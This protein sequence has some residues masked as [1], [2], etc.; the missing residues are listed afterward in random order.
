LS[1]KNGVDE[2]EEQLMMRYVNGMNFTIQDEISMQ[3]MR[4]MEEDCWLVLK[5]KEKLT[6]NV[7]KRPIAREANFPSQEW[8]K[9]NQIWSRGSSSK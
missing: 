5:A 9:S 3:Q 8:R 2:A 1:I 4:M 6:R 7:R